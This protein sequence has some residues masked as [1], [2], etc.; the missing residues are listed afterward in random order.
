MEQLFHL[1]L[2]HINSQPIA[3]AIQ[4]TANV[5]A[6]HVVI[7]IRDGMLALLSTSPLVL[8]IEYIILVILIVLEVVVALIPIYLLS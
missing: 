7:L 6:S 5:T 8:S 3:L 1:S 4:L 2:N